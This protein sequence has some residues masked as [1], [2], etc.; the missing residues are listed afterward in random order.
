MNIGKVIYKLLNSI[1]IAGFDSNNIYPYVV[2]SDV[3]FPVIVYVVEGVDPVSAKNSI[4]RTD[5]FTINIYI[6]SKSYDEAVDIS[7][8]V[9]AAID[10]I[11]NSTITISEE[12]FLIDS[13][14]FK[15][16][17][18]IFDDAAKVFSIIDNYTIRARR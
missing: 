17:K 7:D 3:A 15:S 5:I 4:S 6:F 9:R 2:A 1:T 18:H 16:A 11:H 13:I 14:I 8:T 10:G 12:D